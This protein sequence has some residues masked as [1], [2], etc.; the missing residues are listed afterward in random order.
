MTEEHFTLNFTKRS[1]EEFMTIIASWGYHADLD[2]DS[3]LELHS[4]IYYF[5]TDGDD[6][7]FDKLQ[8][9]T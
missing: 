2:W 1:V 6:E 7:L 9:L 8:S 4:I 3:R 5:L